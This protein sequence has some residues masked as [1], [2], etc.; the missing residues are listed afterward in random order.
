MRCQN[1]KNTCWILHINIASIAKNSNFYRWQVVTGLQ[2]LRHLDSRFNM[3]TEKTHS[4]HCITFFIR[5]QNFAHST[6]YNWPCL[7]KINTISN[8]SFQQHQPNFRRWFSH[9]R[10]INRFI[11]LKCSPFCYSLMHWI[12]ILFHTII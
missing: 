10:I 11:S 8:D 1:L 9:F 7:A 6:F 4:A 2:S 12:C 5:E 3:R